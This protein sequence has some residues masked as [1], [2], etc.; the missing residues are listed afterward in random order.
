MATLEAEDEIKT[1]APKTTAKHTVLDEDEDESTPSST[2]ATND[3]LDVDFGDEALMAKGDGF[4]KIMPPDNDKTR[5]VRVCLLTDVVKPKRD[6]IH[7]VTN[8][9]SFRCNSLRDD[10]FMVTKQAICCKALDADEK[11]KAQLTV[12]C[13]AVWYKNADPTTG[14]YT[15]KKDKQGNEYIDPVEYEI[16][17][18]K[19][20]R[21]AYRRVT[22]LIPEDRKP[23]EIDLLISHKDPIGFE[24]SVI[25]QDARFRK[26][27]ELLAEILEA[28]EPFL[29]GK[30]LTSKLGKKITDLEFA[31]MFSGKAASSSAKAQVDDVSDL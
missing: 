27:P 12:A 29:D 5:V 4:D 8:K 3:N 19:L 16:G 21:S 25:T 24:Y 20:S 14:K 1:P 2:T 9:G 15:K 18:V 22:R 31:A 17:W 26:N 13:L 7:F 11:Q 30:K 28:S 23:H 6:H 10:K